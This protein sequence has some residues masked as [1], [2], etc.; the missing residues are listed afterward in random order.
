MGEVLPTGASAAF[1]AG[2]VGGLPPLA[3]CCCRGGR[4]YG[5]AAP[6]KSRLGAP[7]RVFRRGLSGQLTASQAA[8]GL[9]VLASV[10]VDILGLINAQTLRQLSRALLITRRAR[11]TRIDSTATPKL[12][13]DCR[14]GAKEGAA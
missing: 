3:C 6:P 5:A 7:G 9:P 8:N 10:R 4:S 11:E 2:S 1:A 14:P 12:L 13:R